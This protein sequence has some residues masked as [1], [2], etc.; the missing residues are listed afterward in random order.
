MVSLVDVRCILVLEKAFKFS[1]SIFSQMSQSISE[2]KVWAFPE[3][4]S[5]EDASLKQMVRINRL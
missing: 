1:W 3:P 2:Q 4:G 5:R